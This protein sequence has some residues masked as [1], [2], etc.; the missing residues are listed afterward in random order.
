LAI[1]SVEQDEAFDRRWPV[2]HR[3]YF[4]EMT[5]FATLGPRRYMA[6]IRDFL[7]HRT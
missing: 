4:A 5:T 1:A 6:T 7:G 3:R 2:T